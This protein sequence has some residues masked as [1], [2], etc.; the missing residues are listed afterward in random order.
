MEEEKGS[1]KRRR[2]KEE[3]RERGRFITSFFEC[4]R[5]NQECMMM[6]FYI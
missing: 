1:E 4:T 6:S 5:W 3:G 2:G